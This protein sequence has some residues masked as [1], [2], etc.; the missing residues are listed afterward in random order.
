MTVDQ[1]GCELEYIYRKGCQQILNMYNE[2]HLCPEN[3]IELSVEYD[4]NMT[5]FS[6]VTDDEMEMI[7]S[8]FNSFM[9]SLFIIEI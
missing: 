2:G 6:P 7:S 9:V 8:R 4:E 3:M 5:L 1:K